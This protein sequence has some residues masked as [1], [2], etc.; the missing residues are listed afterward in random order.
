MERSWVA[1]IEGKKYYLLNLSEEERAIEALA[2]IL[3]YASPE[4]ME[5]EGGDAVEVE[6]EETEEVETEETE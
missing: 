6:T 1:Q 2:R 5:E 3:R 4:G